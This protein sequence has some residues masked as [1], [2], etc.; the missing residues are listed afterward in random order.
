MLPHF[1]VHGRRKENRRARGERDRRKRVTGQAVRQF[2]D[3]V[4]CGGRDQQQVR[5]IRKI[6]VTGSP[7]F[8]LV[9]EARRHRIFGKRLQR[10]WRNEFSRILCHDDEYFVTL[11]NEQTG[12]FG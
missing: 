10:Q 5:A 9:V 8:L 2:G 4:R 7:A 11:F 1:S 12:H 3:N 6:D